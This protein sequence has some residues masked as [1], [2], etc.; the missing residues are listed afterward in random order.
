LGF[1]NASSNIDLLGLGP[2]TNFDKPFHSVQSDR[3][4]L[5]TAPFPEFNNRFDNISGTGTILN[6]NTLASRNDSV[7][8]ITRDSALPQAA[9]TA[10]FNGPFI[11]FPSERSTDVSTE[12]PVSPLFFQNITL[13]SH[14]NVCD[15]PFSGFQTP[16]QRLDTDPPVAD[17]HGI[18]KA[19]PEVTWTCEVPVLPIKY[20]PAEWDTVKPKVL[21]LKDAGIPLRLVAEIMSCVHRFRTS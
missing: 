20:T 10:R 12:N 5:Q 3:T 6:P 15:Y 1:D 8:D 21:E 4:R 17:L 11:S 13:A 16:D 18:P 7:N 19:G 14:E 9:A 2:L